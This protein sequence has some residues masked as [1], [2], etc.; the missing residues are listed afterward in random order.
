[1]SP[2]KMSIAAGTRFRIDLG[3]FSSIAYT[4]HEI[5]WNPDPNR[6]GLAPALGGRPELGAS[7]RAQANPPTLALLM[8]SSRTFVLLFSVL[9]LA[10]S[11]H[12]AKETFDR[13]KPHVNIGTI[14]EG[15]A[16]GAS[17]ADAIEA[18]ARV[19]GLPVRDARGQAGRGRA[20]RPLSAQLQGFLVEYQSKNRHYAHVDC[21][22]ERAF[23]P[24]LITGDLPESRLEARS[25]EGRPTESASEPVLDG[26]ILLVSAAEGPTPQTREHV[27]LARQVG[28]PAVVVFL[29]GVDEVRDP[30]WIEVVEKEVRD[31][32][33]RNGFEGDK[34]PIVRGSALGSIRGDARALAAM[35]ELVDTLDRYVPLPPRDKD[36]PF[37]MPVEEAFALGRRGTVATGRIETG[38]VAPG[39]EVEVLGLVPDQIARVGAWP[40]GRAGPRGV[41]EAGDRA[42][43][44]LRSVSGEPLE[45]W[46]GQ[47]V[48]APGTLS[49]HRTCLALVYVFRREEGGRHT[50]FQNKYR[51]QFLFRTTDVTGEITLEDGRELA[52]GDYGWVSVD[53]IVPVAM[54]KGL[55]FAIR[56]GGR[57][58]GAGQ[59]VEILR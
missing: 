21:P 15:G 40:G 27:L 49:S 44:P 17:L 23:V 10:G 4:I 3:A 6:G 8:T 9:A 47:V 53:L 20:A 58:V 29:D 46:P 24:G 51:P 11:A 31:L 35:G 43:L 45:V 48:A 16:G 36:K 52:S 41:L 54:D 14:G 2:I 55:R 59:V 30:A 19:G 56:E 50:P 32:L 25:V 37:L 18:Y 1:M 38:V 5:A 26:V 12:A 34:T 57:T 28:V 39:D 22:S 33:A 42:V 7:G 13:S